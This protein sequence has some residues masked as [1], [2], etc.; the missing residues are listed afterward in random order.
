MINLDKI[1]K[2]NKE[3]YF[4]TLEINRNIQRTEE[5]LFMKTSE[6]LVTMGNSG[7]FPPVPLP[8]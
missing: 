1:V 6:P 4:K 5:H 8:C 3:H 2:Q 7:S